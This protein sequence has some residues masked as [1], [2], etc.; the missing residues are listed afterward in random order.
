MCLKKST[1][2]RE[3]ERERAWKRAKR[4]QQAGERDTQ[5]K[6]ESTRGMVSEEK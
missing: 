3:H 2:E 4:T 1:R 6:G 5:R